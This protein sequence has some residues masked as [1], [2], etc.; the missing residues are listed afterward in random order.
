MG[1]RARRPRC[2]AKGRHSSSLA[3]GIENAEQEGV[4]ISVCTSLSA[5]CCAGKIWCG[6][7]VA[8]SGR[9]MRYSDAML[10]RLGIPIPERPAE[11]VD[12][13]PVE[14]HRSS[15]TEQPRRSKRLRFHGDICQEIADHGTEVTCA[16]SA[17]TSRVLD[18]RGVRGACPRPFAGR[19][20]T[21]MEKRGAAAQ[22]TCFSPVKGPID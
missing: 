18:E 11:V 8:P 21:H 6:S 14:V 10:A 5:C 12:S 2:R 7:L 9:V 22:I 4:A 20:A 13:A 16:T 15:P 3:S 19:R 17:K 1:R